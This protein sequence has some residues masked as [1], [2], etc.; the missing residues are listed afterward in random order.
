MKE[1]L[2]GL[3]LGMVA[4]AFLVKNNKQASKMVDKGNE[5]LKETVQVVEEKM[6]KPKQTTK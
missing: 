5:V 3:G 1:F 6:K 2:F 4:G